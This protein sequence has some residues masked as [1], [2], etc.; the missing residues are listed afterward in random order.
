MKL[1]GGALKKIGMEGWKTN[2]VNGITEIGDQL[3][4]SQHA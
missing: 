4:N 1:G 3:L 2:K